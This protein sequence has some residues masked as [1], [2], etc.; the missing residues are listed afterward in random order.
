MCFMCLRSTV[1]YA[2]KILQECLRVI[3]PVDAAVGVGVSALQDQPVI[4]HHD[5]PGSSQVD[6]EYFTGDAAVG[7]DVVVVTSD[8]SSSVSDY[9]AAGHWG[10]L[11]E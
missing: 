5:F 9:R 2:G 11:A 4:G 1:R 10:G 6:E 3:Y 8:W 7:A